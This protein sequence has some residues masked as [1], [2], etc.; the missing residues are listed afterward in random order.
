MK[1]I[2]TLS[3]KK[4]IRRKDLT[5]LVRLDMGASRLIPNEISNNISTIQK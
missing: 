2:D 1:D 3:G 5:P 4:F